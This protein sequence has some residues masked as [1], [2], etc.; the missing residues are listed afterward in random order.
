[1]QWSFCVFSGQWL[2][3]FSAQ[4]VVF[5]LF[6]VVSGLGYFQHNMSW[7]FC[8]QWS[9]VWGNF[10]HNMPWSFCVQWSVVWGNFQHNMP[11]S[12]HVFSGQWFEV[13][14][15]AIC[16]GLFMCSVVSGLTSF[17]TPYVVVFLCVQWSVA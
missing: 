12:F 16:R 9:V 4:Y 13:I 17:L 7:S 11:W 10:Q 5:F 1:M 2:G 3:V 15:S 8:F 14:S 6:S